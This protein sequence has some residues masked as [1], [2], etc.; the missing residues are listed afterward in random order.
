MGRSTSHQA[1][2][3]IAI[4]IQDSTSSRLLRT[5]RLCNNSGTHS[6]HS[7]TILHRGS[8]IWRVQL[9]ASLASVG[10]FVRK[11]PPQP[12]LPSIRC[13]L[14]TGSP[15]RCARSASPGCWGGGGAKQAGKG[16][17]CSSTTHLS[18]QHQRHGTKRAPN[19]EQ[20]SSRAV[21]ALLLIHICNAMTPTAR[22]QH[23]PLRS[24][25]D[26]GSSLGR[27]DLCSHRSRSRLGRAAKQTAGI[28]SHF[29][30]AAMSHKEVAHCT[31]TRTRLCTGNSTA[32]TV[33]P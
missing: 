22:T 20:P 21:N 29:N 13:N 9:H 1:L 27:L 18:D 30:E 33:M 32:G 28:R 6:R 26:A 15:H 31:R 17:Q 2:I 23:P 19:T 8:A 7:P 11:V 24:I 10:K 14:Q 3:V 25:G 12:A 5:T 4:T 16:T